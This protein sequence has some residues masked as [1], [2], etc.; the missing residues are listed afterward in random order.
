MRLRTARKILKSLSGPGKLRRHGHAIYDAGQILAAD[1]RYAR[2]R[3]AKLA[4]AE[5][6]DFAAMWRRS[7]LSYRINE[8]VSQG[9]IAEAFRM[10]MEGE[11]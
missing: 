2:T 6:L 11:L 7:F 3:S 10:L 4:T 8:L 1:R 9:K 5:I